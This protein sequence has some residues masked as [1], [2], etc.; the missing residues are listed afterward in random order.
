[1]EKFFIDEEE[2]DHIEEMDGI[3]SLENLPRTM[4]MMRNLESESSDWW[5]RA[6]WKY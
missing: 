6:Y 1:M 4:F 5:W 2:L 3:L